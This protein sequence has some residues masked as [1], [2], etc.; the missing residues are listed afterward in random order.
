MLLLCWDG[1]NVCF[2]LWLR[3]WLTIDTLWLTSDLL[4]VKFDSFSLSTI[5]KWNNIISS[6]CRI[7]RLIAD[8]MVQIENMI[9]NNRST[10]RV[11]FKHLLQV[12]NK[13]SLTGVFVYS[14]VCMLIKLPDN[15]FICLFCWLL[16]L[17][18]CLFT[19][20][21]TYDPRSLIQTSIQLI[22]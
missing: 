19:S 7:Q 3:I 11:N 9:L 15:L 6:I 13:T 17:F 2:N 8:Y 20:M 4:S 12:F 22:Q 1:F 18:N 10:V 16:H 5:I 21:F 14:R